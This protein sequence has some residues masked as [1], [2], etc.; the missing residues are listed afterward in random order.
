[1]KTR[2]AG[3]ELRVCAAFQ[4]P[5]LHEATTEDDKC[6]HLFALGLDCCVLSQKGRSWQRSIELHRR[7]TNGSQNTRGSSWAIQTKTMDFCENSLP[8][9]INSHSFPA[10]LWRLVNN[11]AIEA[12]YWDKLGEVI[13]VDRRLFE[14]L[15]LSP[16]SIISD[17]ADTFKTTRFSSFIRQL[18]LYGFKKADQYSRSSHHWSGDNGACHRFYNPN[19]KR[20]QPELIANLWR[21]TAGNKAK[22]QAGLNVT[23]QP[24]FRY[25]EKCGGDRNR[26]KPVKGGGSSLLSTKHQAAINPYTLN[27]PQG[28]TAY[29]ETPVPPLDLMRSQG[30][31]LPC[32]FALKQHYPSVTS[33]SSAQAE[34]LSPQTSYQS[35]Y[36]ANMSCHGKHSQASQIMEKQEEEN[37][38]ISLD[39]IFQIADEVMHTP[40]NNCLVN[41]VTTEKSAAILEPSPTTC[42]ATLSDSP[43]SNMNEEF[44]VSI[45]EQMLEDVL[46]D[47][48]LFSA[49]FL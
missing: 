8:S 42:E 39:T 24:P 48:G 35:G 27:K 10:K 7:G 32:A 40:T 17:P 41:V 11:P 43:A 12:I 31:Y 36:N 2:C 21:L 44:V 9:N 13:I 23:C 5:G 15:I 19:F 30:A 1:M 45:T 33:S 34:L 37:W 25:E 6:P 20:N 26:H 22:L 47:L 29:T 4:Q 28:M 14:K 16:S 49:G 18:N 46:S 38:H 3:T